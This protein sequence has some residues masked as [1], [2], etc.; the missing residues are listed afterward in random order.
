M[1]SGIELKLVRA[2]K[3]KGVEITEEIQSAMAE[4]GMMFDEDGTLLYG[5]KI[6]GEYLEGYYDM[7]SMT[8]IESLRVI[9]PVMVDGGF[10]E[11]D[12]NGDLE[13]Y[14][15]ERGLVGHFEPSIT[16]VPAGNKDG[17]KSVTIDAD[18]IDWGELRLGA[19]YLEAVQDLEDNDAYADGLRGL[20]DQID[21]IQ[22]SAMKSLGSEVVMP[23]VVFESSDGEMIDYPAEKAEDI[24]DEPKC[25]PCD[26]L[27]SRDNR[28]A[29][30][31]D[32]GC[33]APR[34]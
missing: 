31:E 16:W 6:D 27:P 24:L 17:E 9:A 8:F 10:V 28:G 12:N 19:M 30:A 7:V 1:S 18:K 21:A 34:R 2:A 25:A 23:A 29:S 3:R 11:L 26:I 22:N 32:E 20:L 5:R 15:F 4:Q 33:P 13:R 14:V